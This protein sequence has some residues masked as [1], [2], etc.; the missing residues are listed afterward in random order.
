MWFD[1]D[2]TNNSGSANN[3]SLL[4]QVLRV[5]PLNFLPD[6]AVIGKMP[7]LIPANLLKYKCPELLTCQFKE[8][9]PRASYLPV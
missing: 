3:Q 1:K 6:I 4:T 8:Q 7:E 2:T 5:N 9:I